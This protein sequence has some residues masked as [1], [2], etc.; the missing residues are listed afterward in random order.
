MNR[1]AEPY[2]RLTE[3]VHGFAAARILQVAVELDVFSKLAND[4]K[5][6]AQLSTLLHVHPGAL[7][8]F[9][10]REAGNSSCALRWY[11]LPVAHGDSALLTL[12]KTA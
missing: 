5:T 6:A 10:N 8:L 1:T 9:L 12:A 11:S 4:G 3:V 7:E 2:L